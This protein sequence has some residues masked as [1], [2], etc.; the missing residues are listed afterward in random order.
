M[1]QKIAIFCKASISD[2]TIILI[3]SIYVSVG[4]HFF[5]CLF[6]LGCF[7]VVVV[8]L[9][10]LVFFCFVLVSRVPGQNGVFQA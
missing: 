10:F 3:L 5:V 8:V 1:N 6:V 2:V 4:V 9:G 7:F